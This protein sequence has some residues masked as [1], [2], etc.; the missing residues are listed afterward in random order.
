MEKEILWGVDQGIGRLTF[1]RPE[2]ANSLGLACRTDM[3]EGIKRMTEPDVRVVV[4]AGQ[5]KFFNAGGDI[6]EFLEN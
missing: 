2:H 3:I 4:I 6:S 1:N 5:G